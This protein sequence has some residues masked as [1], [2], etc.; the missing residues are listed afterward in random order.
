MI[1][2]MRLLFVALV[3]FTIASCGGSAETSD[4]TVINQVARQASD[5]PNLIVFFTDDQGWSDIGIHNVKDDVKT[6]NI[7]SL[8]QSGVRFSNGYITSPQCSPSRAAMHTGKYQQQFGM[9][10]NR[11]VPMALNVTTIAD[12]FN[13]AGYT[14]GLVGKWH[15]DINRLSVEWAQ[16]NYPS[17]DLSNFTA[18][19]IPFDI[20]T[21]YFPSSRGYD[22]VYTGN[23][24]RF[25]SNFDL[26]GNTKELGY[27]NNSDYRIDVVSDAADAFIRKNAQAPFYLH[28]AHFGPHVPIEAPEKYLNQFPQDMPTRRRYAL[29]SMFAID[30]GVGKIIETLTELKLIEN[31]MI[32]FIS[33]NGAPLGLD[34]TD[35][36]IDDSTEQ[37]NGSENTPMRGEKGMLTEGGIRVPFI[38]SMPGTIPQ[39]SIINEPAMSIDVLATAL[40]FAGGDISELDGVDL[41]PA[42]QDQTNYLTERPLFWR[43]LGQQ[44]IRKGNWKYLEA[45]DRKYLFDMSADDP[46]GQNLINMFPDIAEA[47]NN[48]YKIW[49]SGLMRADDASQVST[50]M[51]QRYDFHLLSDKNP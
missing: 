43:F 24:T 6:P 28:V 36:A 49:S 10:N 22:F 39:D 7:D 40:K 30:K 35:S 25:W 27:T 47:L 13:A 15:L 17:A 20:R 26:N 32:V 4:N 21:Q 45:D 1:V 31:T 2:C 41:L 12:R 3:F 42:F 19:Q 23:I 44:A 5:N 46:E 34:K 11:F 14:T 29:A 38:M 37:W 8:S 50:D 9:D 16:D 48:E 51:K 18:D 33:D